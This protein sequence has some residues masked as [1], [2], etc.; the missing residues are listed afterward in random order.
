MVGL[1]VGEQHALAY[2]RHASCE[3]RWLFDLDPKRAAE[4]IGRHALP[5]AAATSY[6]SILA[7]PSVNVVSLASYDDAHHSQVVSALR[8]GKHVF[9]EK[10]LCTARDELNEI[11]DICAA[12]PDLKLM[13]NLVLRSSPLFRWLRDYIRDG[14]L[15]TIY[16]F[17]SEYLYGRIEKITAGWRA[18]VDGYSAMAGGGVHLV[19]LMIWLT[20]ARP[21]A[22]R[23]VGNR[24]CTAGSAFRY[25]DYV[26]ST[27]EFDSGMLGRVTANFGCVHPHQHVLRI[28][29]T[30]GTFIYDDSGPRL[31]AGRDR[32]PRLERLPHAPLPATKGDLIPSFVS[33][34]LD[35]AGSCCR[36][37]H[38]FEVIAACCAA[39]SSLQTHQ[40]QE[41][42]YP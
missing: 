6:A 37:Q 25:D 5:A 30:K 38:E 41:I 14:R 23:S 28:Y 10:P 7:D 13:S 31:H 1:G 24:I 8:A 3:L 4:V 19:D 9:C 16:S 39:E 40:R 22:V 42:D 11:S 35:E 27:F 18:H 17:D 32:S 36:P 29:G 26:A 34:I 21:R 2:H 12:R 20:G 15:G 33:A